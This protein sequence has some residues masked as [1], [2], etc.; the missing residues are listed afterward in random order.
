LI[1]FYLDRT[2]GVSA[3]VGNAVREQDVSSPAMT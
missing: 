1:V 2:S 3:V